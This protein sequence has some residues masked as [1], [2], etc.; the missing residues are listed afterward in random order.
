MVR[1]AVIGSG[2]IGASVGLAAKRGGDDVVVAYD[3]DERASATAVE[4]GGADAAAESLPAALDGAALAVVAVP[5]AALAET[6]SAALASS[7]D[8]CTVTDVGSTKA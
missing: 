8:A 1:I 3:A 2:L 6:V 5:V 4:R 7:G